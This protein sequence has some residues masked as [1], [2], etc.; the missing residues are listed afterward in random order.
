M[1]NN[2][3]GTD[4]PFKNVKTNIRENYAKVYLNW[5]IVE[6][7]NDVKA[8]K[9]L[10]W[11]WLWCSMPI[12]SVLTRIA[13]KMPLW[14]ILLSTHRFITAENRRH[15]STMSALITTWTSHTTFACTTMYSVTKYD[16]QWFRILTSDY[17]KFDTNTSNRNTFNSI[18]CET[19][20]S[21][22]WIK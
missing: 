3:E 8:T 6:I 2:T 21:I 4:L 10:S 14:K 18:C 7:N 16:Y 1:K 17:R 9:V 15:T 11:T 13:I 20:S 12:L 22:V 5:R 19:N